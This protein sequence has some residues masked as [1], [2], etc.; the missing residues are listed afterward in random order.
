MDPLSDRITLT[1]RLRALVL[2]STLLASTVAA[3]SRGSGEAAS[4]TI[5]PYAYELG[6][7]GFADDPLP[8]AVVEDVAMHYP[9]GAF[10]QGHYEV[11][12]AE[13]HFEETIPPW[14][15]VR[16]TSFDED[17]TVGWSDES[18]QYKQP[19]CEA[20]RWGGD[21]LVLRT[22]LHVIF[23]VQYPEPWDETRCDYHVEGVA[24]QGVLRWT[25]GNGAF[26]VNEHGQLQQKIFVGGA[27]NTRI[28]DHVGADPAVGS[29]VTG[30]GTGIHANVYG[31]NDDGQAFTT[32]HD[33]SDIQLAVIPGADDVVPGSLAMTEANGNGIF[34]VTS[35]GD[36]LRAWWQSGWNVQTIASP[37]A[38]IVPGSLVAD[39]DSGPQGR[40]YGVD[41]NG[42][43]VMTYRDASGI[44]AIVIPGLAQVVSGSLAHSRGNG[45]FA[46]DR[47]GRLLRIDWD[48]GFVIEVIPTFGSAL[49]PRSMVP[50]WQTGADANIY[51][52]NAAG[53]IFSVWNDGSSL[54]FALV[55]GTDDLHPE[56]LVATTSDSGIFGVRTSGE[57]TRTWWEAGSFHSEVIPHFGGPLVPESL[58]VGTS[59]WDQVIG[60]N[61]DGQ[62]FTT[63]EVGGTTKFG[64]VP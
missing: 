64:L 49:E 63:Y 51:G 34:G 48:S 14:L 44:Q 4:G 22:W 11:N 41:E 58:A 33:G 40:V 1:H 56:S 5:G 12:L 57:L 24:R 32:W 29:I 2:V 36:F 18:P 47:L 6:F 9:Y 17:G 35:T 52:V 42:Q 39:H 46:I 50:G 31:V 13:I 16:S 7:D 62:M 60:V 28:V 10:P 23:N 3:Q 59:G 38:P 27:W 61:E 43:V 25:D 54:Q 53:K 21:E 15:T 26:G 45:V 37:G 19:W 30:E 55:P 8:R 20:L